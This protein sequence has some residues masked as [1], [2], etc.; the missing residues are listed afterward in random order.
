MSCYPKEVLRSFLL[1]R[2]DQGL[3]SQVSGHLH[4]CAACREALRELS[5]DI[6]RERGEEPPS[7]KRPVIVSGEDHFGSMEQ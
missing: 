3:D 7:V 2:L 5:E 1:R 6:L 4:L